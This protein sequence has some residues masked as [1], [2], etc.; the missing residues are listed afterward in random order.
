MSISFVYAGA[1]GLLRQDVAARLEGAGRDGVDGEE[2]REA[3]GATPEEM[4]RALRT[5]LAEGRAVE[6]GGRWYRPQAQQRDRGVGRASG[7]G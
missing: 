1:E 3:A 2:L 5:L 7:G 4:E 6:D